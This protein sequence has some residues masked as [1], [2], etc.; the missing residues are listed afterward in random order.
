MRKCKKK[1]P[2]ATKRKQQE[3]ASA[4]WNGL[5]TEGG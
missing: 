1:P 5:L 2:F 4:E 3:K